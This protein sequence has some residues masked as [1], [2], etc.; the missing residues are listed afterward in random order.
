MSAGAEDS[1]AS[2]VVADVVDEVGAVVV[3]VSD[4]LLVVG[5]AVGLLVVGEVVLAAVE[6]DVEVAGVEVTEPVEVVAGL[7]GDVACDVADVWS[8]LSAP[9]V[10]LG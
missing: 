2:V 10:E 5:D 8:V 6:G 3:T 9:T 1:D 7:V 4:E